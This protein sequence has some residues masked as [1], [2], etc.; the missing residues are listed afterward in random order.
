MKLPSGHTARAVEEWIGSSPDAKIPDEVCIRIFMRYNGKDGKTGQRLVPGCFQFDHIKPLWKGGEHRESNLW[1]LATET[2]KE[3]TKQEAAERAKVKRLQKKHF[4][5][6]KES[7][8]PKRS[9]N[10]PRYDNT[11]FIGG[12]T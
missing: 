12:E 6:K 10:Q 1:P 9:F 2:H 4:L 5:P 8:W 7:K 3:K 11:K